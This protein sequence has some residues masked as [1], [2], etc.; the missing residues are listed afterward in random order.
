MAAAAALACP[1]LATAGAA[2]ARA[3]VGEIFAAA[4]RSSEVTYSANARN[5]ARLAEGDAS[6]GSRFEEPRTPAAARR[7][8]MLGCRF[9]AARERAGV[10]GERA[11][12][13]RVLAGDTAFMLGALRALDCPTCA[14]GIGGGSGGAD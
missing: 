1:T 13:E 4:A 9:E 5:F 14:Y 10:S 11:C 3:D 6:A 7:R 2:P 12:N 8:A